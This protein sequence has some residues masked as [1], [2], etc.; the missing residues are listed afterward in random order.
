M[1]TG[2]GMPPPAPEACFPIL[3]ARSPPDQDSGSAKYLSLI[4]S[5]VEFLQAAKSSLCWSELLHQVLSVGSG[6][7]SQSLKGKSCPW[8][9][10]LPPLAFGSFFARTPWVCSWDLQAQAPCLWPS[11]TAGGYSVS[12]RVFLCAERRE[13]RC[14]A[15]T[16]SVCAHVYPCLLW[17]RIGQGSTKGRCVCTVSSG[18]SCGAMLQNVA[19]PNSSREEV[20]ALHLPALMCSSS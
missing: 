19:L 6:L 7:L 14:W 15:Q 4:L 3:R 17:V 1:F 8:S 5:V 16:A 11:T 2:C 13:M 10:P 9:F 18:T 12:P 20:Q